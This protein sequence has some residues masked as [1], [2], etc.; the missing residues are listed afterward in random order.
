MSLTITALNMTMPPRQGLLVLCLCTAAVGLAGAGASGEAGW[1]A[2][3]AAL[4]AVCA[5][6]LCWCSADSAFLAWAGRR[7][8]GG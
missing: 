3:W 4:L 2:A 5:C 6:C 7:T 8:E 1:D